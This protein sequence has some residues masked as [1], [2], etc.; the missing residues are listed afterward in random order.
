MEFINDFVTLLWQ[1]KFRWKNLQ[2]ILQCMLQDIIA[3][4]FHHYGA[5]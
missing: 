2:F 1:K 5:A 3:F 4:V